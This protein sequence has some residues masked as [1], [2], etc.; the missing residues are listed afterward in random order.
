MEPQKRFGKSRSNSESSDFKSCGSNDRVSNPLRTNYKNSEKKPLVNVP[1]LSKL[2][3]S[4]AFT[5]KDI[6][7]LDDDELK[8]RT[9]FAS[10]GNMT[11]ISILL[12]S[13]IRDVFLLYF[14]L[15]IKLCFSTL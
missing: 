6:L 1:A 14:H 12:Y 9:K 8:T 2:S 4:K 3:N 11:V 7:G 10:A 15:V 5:I 13:I